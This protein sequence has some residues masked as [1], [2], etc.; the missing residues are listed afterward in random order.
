MTSDMHPAL[1][2]LIDD[3]TGTHLYIVSSYL[4]VRQMFEALSEQVS[5]LKNSPDFKFYTHGERIRTAAGG[6]LMIVPKTVSVD[7]LRGLRLSS[8]DKDGDVSL[9][10][11]KFSDY[12]YDAK[13]R[14]E[15]AKTT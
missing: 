12:W 5:P 9:Y 6:Q 4:R 8:I 1:R 13:A 11:D 2:R 7:K 14:I 15:H 10:D 3:P